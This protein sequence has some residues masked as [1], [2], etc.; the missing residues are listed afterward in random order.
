MSGSLFKSC[1]PQACNFIKKETLAQVF[2]CEFCKI[3]EN[4]FSYGQVDSPEL[5]ETP[6]ITKMTENFAKVTK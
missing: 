4:N 2:Y 1:K 3:S 5:P 6:E